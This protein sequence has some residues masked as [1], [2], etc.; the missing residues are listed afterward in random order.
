MGTDCKS[1]ILLENILSFPR[2][3]DLFDILILKHESLLNPLINQ[4]EKD[5]IY[6]ETE[7]KI[8]NCLNETQKNILI[9][10]TNLVLRLSRN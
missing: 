7:E 3:R 4:Q 1:A 9:P 5:F 6:Q 10:D 2:H 8:F